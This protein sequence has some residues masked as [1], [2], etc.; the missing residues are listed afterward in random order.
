MVLIA[1]FSFYAVSQAK[2]YAG[3]SPDTPVADKE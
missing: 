3:Q 2:K 1:I